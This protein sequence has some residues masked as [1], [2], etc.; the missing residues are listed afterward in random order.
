MGNIVVYVASVF[1]PYASIC[2]QAMNMLHMLRNSDHTP[3]EMLKLSPLKAWLVRHGH[4]SIAKFAQ[5][6]LA[7]YQAP[8]VFQVRHP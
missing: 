3:Q 7:N 6:E 8:L 4:S 5:L 1:Y 2:I